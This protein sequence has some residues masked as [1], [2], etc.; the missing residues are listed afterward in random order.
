MQIESLVLWEVRLQSR[1][2]EAGRLC[3]SGGS[4][5]KVFLSLSMRSFT[6]L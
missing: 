4:G 2:W 1:C 3:S 5:G 6:S